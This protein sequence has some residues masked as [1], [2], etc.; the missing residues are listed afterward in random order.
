MKAY[1]R[2]QSPYRSDFIPMSIFWWAAL[3][4]AQCLDFD[5]ICWTSRQVFAVA[6]WRDPIGPIGRQRRPPRYPGDSQLNGVRPADRIEPRAWPLAILL[7]LSLL[8]VLEPE[9]ESPL[10]RVSVSVLPPVPDDLW[11]LYCSLAVDCSSALVG[12]LRK[13]VARAER[14]RGRKDEPRARPPM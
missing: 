12:F 2:A 7:P 6:R 1:F 13:R 9:P 4:S 14:R 11:R 8:A 10:G 3:S 5:A